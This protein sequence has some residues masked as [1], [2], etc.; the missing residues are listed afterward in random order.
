MRIRNVRPRWLIVGATLILAVLSA[1]VQ[2]LPLPVAAPPLGEL[3]IRI[4]DH[5]EAID[6]FKELW[7]SVGAI[8]IH[9]SG[10][11]REQGWVHIAVQQSQFDLTQQI[12]GS[13]ALVARSKIAV[14]H[15][16]AVR[17]SVAQATGTLKDHTPVQVTIFD[18]PVAL[19]LSI[20]ESRLSV[21]R[22]D[23]VVM[24][25]RDHPGGTYELHFRE[26]MVR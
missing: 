6:D 18:G 21:M 2:V 19:A 26:A 24:S 16:D 13:G 8:A 3:Q 1:G 25:A 7:V 14:G 15:Y 23:L 10:A 9:R 5:R 17:L 4:G 20:Q 22:L 12:G 11:A